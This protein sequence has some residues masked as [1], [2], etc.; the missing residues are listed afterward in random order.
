LSLNKKKKNKRIK[1]NKRTRDWEI[2]KVKNSK[3]IK[4]IRI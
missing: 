1:Y 4:T 2:V 3:L